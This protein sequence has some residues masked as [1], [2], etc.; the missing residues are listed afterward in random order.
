M[1]IDIYADDPAAIR[2]NSP[3]DHTVGAVVVNIQ[4]L[5]PIVRSAGYRINRGVAH[6]AARVASAQL[7]HVC[8]VGV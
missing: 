3:E 1:H 2:R 7:Q 6:Q 5:A 8:T 4:D